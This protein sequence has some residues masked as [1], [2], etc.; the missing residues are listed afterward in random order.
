MDEKIS[1]LKNHLPDFLVENKSLYSIL[2]K[3]IH[4]LSEQGCLGAFPIVKLGIEMILDEKIREKER[5]AKEE[6][7]RK[8]IGKLTEELKGS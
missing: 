6:E 8:A 4:E 5:K 7:A 1:L 2:S 3:G